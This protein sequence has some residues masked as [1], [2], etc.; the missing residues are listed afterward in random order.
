MLSWCLYWTVV[1]RKNV[2]AV[3]SKS[4][5][6]N[7]DLGTLM[8]ETI[9]LK[10]HFTSFFLCIAVHLYV[11]FQRFNLW[12]I[13]NDFKAPVLWHHFCALFSFSVL[14][15]RRFSTFACESLYSWI[16]VNS[17]NT[18]FPISCFAI[19]MK[20][21]VC[22]YL[23]REVTLN[24]RKLDVSISVVSGVNWIQDKKIGKT[25]LDTIMCIC[26]LFC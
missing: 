5:V 19:T 13:L 25:I 4:Q 16:I 14:F 26:V 12:W 7:Y 21:L 24:G 2:S 11:Q 8:T 22:D 18:L 10:H 9:L 3:D 23:A 15:E 6:W 17:Y 20:E 1:V